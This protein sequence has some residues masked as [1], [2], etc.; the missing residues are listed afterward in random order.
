MREHKTV[1][2][3]NGDFVGILGYAEDNFLLSPTLDG[4]QEMRDTWA[5]YAFEQNLTFST[6][7]NPKK[8]KTE[9]M[10]FLQEKRSKR[11]P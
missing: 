3:I 6:N 7:K 1:C 4:L 8:N 5:D 10:A 9:C 11:T 2:W